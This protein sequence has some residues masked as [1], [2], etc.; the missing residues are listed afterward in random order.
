MAVSHTTKSKT[1]Q[2]LSTKGS[3]A[4]SFIGVEIFAHSSWGRIV[5]HVVRKGFAVG[6]G[7][8]RLHASSGPLTASSKF[9]LSNAPGKLRVK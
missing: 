4:I 7:N 2:G 1:V 6:T 8:A 5:E 9:P 3:L